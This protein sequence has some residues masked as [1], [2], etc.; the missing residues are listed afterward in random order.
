MQTIM[1]PDL[2]QPTEEIAGLCVAVLP[3]LVEVH[4]RMLPPVAARA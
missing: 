2:V 3:S 4:R 1:V